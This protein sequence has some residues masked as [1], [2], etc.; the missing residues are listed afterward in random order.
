MIPFSVLQQKLV[1]KLDMYDEKGRSKAM[2]TTV[3]AGGIPIPLFLTVLNSA[4]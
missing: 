3:T 2:K 4:E 1:I